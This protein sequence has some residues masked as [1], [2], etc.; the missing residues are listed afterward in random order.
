[1]NQRFNLKQRV[2]ALFMAA[3]MCCTMFPVGA[4]AEAPQ[5]MQTVRLPL[6]RTTKTS[7]RMHRKLM[8]AI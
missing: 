7:H 6:C 2:A 8:K 4:F 1:M 3:M 5:P